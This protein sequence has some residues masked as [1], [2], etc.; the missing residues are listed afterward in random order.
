MHKGPKFDVSGSKTIPYMGFWSQDPQILSTWTLCATVVGLCGEPITSH[1]EEEQSQ[2]QPSPSAFS[3]PDPICKAG[4]E[5]RHARIQYLDLQS[6]KKNGAIFPNRQCTQYRV[7]CF[8]YFG[9]F[10]CPGRC[11]DPS[12]QRPRVHGRGLGCRSKS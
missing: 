10:G 9:C 4:V 8:G 6:A 1:L 12:N 3:G 2:A 7:H 5:Q 11:E